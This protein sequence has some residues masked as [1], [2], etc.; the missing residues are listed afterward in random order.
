MSST[1]RGIAAA[2]WCLIVAISSVSASPNVWGALAT[3]QNHLSSFSS[4]K[5]VNINTS[6][7]VNVPRGGNIESGQEIESNLMSAEETLT[8]FLDKKGSSGDGKFYVHGW[9][10][11]TMSLLR[12]AGRLE[13]LA[14]RMSLQ[15]HNNDDDD[16]DNSSLE[17]ASRHVVDFNMKGLHRIETD[18]AF[19]WL[20]KKLSADNNC[21]EID[22]NIANAFS[23]LLNRLS[24]DRQKIAQLGIA[25]KDQSKIVSTVGVSDSKRYDAIGRVAQLSAALTSKTRSVLELED[26]FLV[27]AVAALVPASEQKSFNSKVIRKLGVLDSRLHLVGMYD[28]VQEHKNELE[29][30]L[31]Q[32]SIPYIPRKMI[33]RWRKN[34]YDPQAGVLDEV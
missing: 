29:R 32:E 22:E 17:R 21:L 15:S 16:C 3:N 6:T 1:V 2:L 18:L 25:V 13:K 23:T 33:P 14:Y 10:W 31:F 4:W 28:A 30:E 34:L 7:A 26:K 8:K 24:E 11:H 27:P 9:R 19:P 12:D 20:E 5:N